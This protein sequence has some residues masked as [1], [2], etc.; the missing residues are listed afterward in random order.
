[1]SVLGKR[2]AEDSLV[3]TVDL[4]SDNEDS[5][6]VVQNLSL[7]KEN[8]FLESDSNQP[9]D[10]EEPHV[11]APAENNQDH[12]LADYVQSTKKLILDRISERSLPDSLDNLTTQYDKLLHL[13]EQTV[14]MG[15]SNSCLLV[16]NRGSGKSTLV[17]KAIEELENEHKDNFLVVEL[18]G[19]VQTD[20]KSALRE[21]TRQLT[22]ESQMEGRS[23]V[24]S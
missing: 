21:I 15:E 19:L 5:E 17:R 10:V 16:G 11:P 4:D 8:P 1:M 13:L 9:G 3:S 23:F 7:F 20:D 22:R 18:N 24:C 12:S 6:T 2:K 14:K